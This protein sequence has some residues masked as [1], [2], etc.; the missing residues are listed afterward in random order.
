ML[1]ALPWLTSE[2]ESLVYEIN[3]VAAQLARQACEEVEK[4]TAK[5]RYVAGVLGPH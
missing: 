5:K 1:P 4:L 3:Q 2:M